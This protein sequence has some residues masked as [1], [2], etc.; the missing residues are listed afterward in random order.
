MLIKR[1]VL[2]LFLNEEEWSGRIVYH[3][4]FGSRS[5]SHASILSIEIASEHHARLFQI[6]FFVVAEFRCQNLVFISR[7]D[8]DRP[9]TGYGP[10]CHRC[11]T[12]GAGNFNW[13]GFPAVLERIGVFELEVGILASTTQAV[14]PVTTAS[15]EPLYK[16]ILG[17]SRTEKVG[18]TNGAQF[19][20]FE[21][22]KALYIGVS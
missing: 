8:L 11:K 16:H 19:R 10:I 12:A 4:V 15:H 18:S 14:S 22:Q 2:Q 17:S 21:F 9:F 5:S 3:L 20:Y 7:S 13:L 1:N 6:L